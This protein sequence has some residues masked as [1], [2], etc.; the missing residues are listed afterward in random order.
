MHAS[1]WLANRLLQSLPVRRVRNLARRVLERP[2]SPLRA[3]KLE[4]L[5]EY[6]AEVDRDWL[7]RRARGEEVAQ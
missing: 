7:Q 5:A 4:R 3:R 2:E 1:R 6:V